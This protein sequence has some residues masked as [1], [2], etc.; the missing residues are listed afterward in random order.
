MQ[1]IR[2]SICGEIIRGEIYCC[3]DSFLSGT[4]LVRFVLNY[5]YYST[6]WGLCHYTN[7]IKLSTN[8]DSFHVLCFIVVIMI[9]N[10]HSRM[11]VAKYPGGRRA[12]RGPQL[13]QG[14]R[15]EDR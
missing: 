5:P 10:D 11:I 14:E 8:Q 2:K 4:R 13:Q 7:N 6:F 9:L 15:K 3:H 1:I 12:E